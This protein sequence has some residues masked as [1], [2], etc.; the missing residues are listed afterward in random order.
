MTR[1]K[2]STKGKRSATRKRTKKLGFRVAV[3]LP[4]NGA[5]RK[6]DI[7][8]LNQ[9]ET[10][11]ATDRGDLADSRERARLAKKLTK[12]LGKGTPEQWESALQQAYLAAMREQKTAQKHAEES[13]PSP[14]SPCSPCS[15][16]RI[17]AGRICFVRHSPSGDETLVPLSNFT[18]NVTEIRR[19]D[20]GSG[21]VEQ[22]FTVIGALDE[23]TALPP[24]TLRAA[25]FVSMNWPV[26][27][28]GLRSIVTPGQNSRDHLRAAIQWFSDKATERTIYKHTGWRSI[29]GAWNYLHAQGAIASHGVNT[30]VAVDLTGP[31]ARYALPTPPD[32]DHLRDVVR[33]S[34]GLHSVFPGLFVP[35][36]G[37]VYRTVLGPIDWSL[38]IVGHTGLGKSEAI[39]IGQQHFG[40]EMNRLN[41]PASWQ[42]TGNALVELAFLAKD[43]LLVI[44]DFKPA[45][46]KN[47]IDQMHQLAERVLR[48]QGNH[49]GRA[50]CRADGTV[51]APRP[52]RAAI[53]SSG[54]DVPRGES[55]RAR[56]FTLQVTKNDIDVRMLTPFQH[57]AAQGRYAAA[58]AGYVRWLAS[59]LD[60]IK[61]ALDGERSELRQQA[62]SVNGHARTPGIV[63]DLALGWRYFL[64]F[65]L[66]VGAITDAERK[67][68]AA[69]VWTILLKAAAKQNEEI[70]EQD[71][72]T[73][74]FKLVNAALTSGRA[75][76]TNR[77]GSLPDVPQMWGWRPDDVGAEQSSPRWKPQGRQIGWIDEDDLYLDNEAAYAEVQ[78]LGDEQGERLALTK[79]QLGK[80]LKSLGMLL[81][82]ETDKT[83]IRKTLQGRERAVWHLSMEV[84]LPEK[85]GRTGRTGRKS[86]EVPAEGMV[87]S[88]GL[89]NGLAE[90][91][92]QTGGIPAANPHRLPVPPVLPVFEG[93]TSVV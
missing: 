43:T 81:S 91:G 1:R 7:A 27:S 33:S 36:L 64:A 31:L 54:E 90:P 47:S 23:G 70:A 13:P 79:S 74:F 35:I 89:Q 67:A 41:L 87:L 44:D 62:L 53:L 80:H 92:D 3:T 17:E 24:T 37:Q 93:G 2:T 39:A 32:G 59:R 46:T 49:S 10:T 66:D 61:A 83:T 76:V 29:D 56:T 84:L 78:E 5:S 55:L 9:D 40:P 88:P 69:E 14:C 77:L 82:T 51:R 57:E 73:R 28:W 22:Y 60:Q 52:P 26:S 21:D 19:I 42:S 38:H 85:T 48:A 50:R 8:I 68:I 4:T 63:A 11:V 45:G 20:D 16:Y 65:A 75:H 72:A 12:Q 71:P 25:E 15:V 30:T 6:A 34:I 86:Q 18:A 58:M